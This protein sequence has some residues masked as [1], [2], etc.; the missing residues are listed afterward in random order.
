MRYGHLF[1]F[2]LVWI[3]ILAC[4]YD[5]RVDQ[6]RAATPRTGTVTTTA[7]AVTPPVA[8]AFP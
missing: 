7:G 4:W 2:G 5:D 3:A 1:L 6:Q 8:G